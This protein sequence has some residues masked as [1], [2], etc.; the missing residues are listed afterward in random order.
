MNPLK[1]NTN[2]ALSDDPLKNMTH[3]A[4]LNADNKVEVK[5]AM[6]HLPLLKN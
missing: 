5:K 1:S 4:V 3:D 6:K 2:E